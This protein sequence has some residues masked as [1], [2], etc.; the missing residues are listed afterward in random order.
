MQDDSADP[1]LTDLTAALETARREGSR[2]ERAIA[3]H[4]LRHLGALP[5]ETAASV[6]QKI[7]VSEST[8][9]RFCR[10]LGYAHFKALKAALQTDPG[11]GPWLIGDRLRAFHGRALQGDAALAQGMERE[12]A[13]I[14]ANYE[15]AA[16]P[17]FAR[18]AARLAR[19][20]AVWIAGF[21]TERGHAADLAHT[22]QYLRPGVQLADLSGGHFSEVLLSSPAETCLVLF[23]GRRYSRLTRA[24]AQAARQKGIAVTLITDPWCDWGQ[25]LADECLAVQTDLGQ[26]WDS[27]AAM[28]SL[29][30]LL[31][32]RV[33]REL[34][35][36][37]VEARLAQVAGL[38]NDFIGQIGGA[39]GAGR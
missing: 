19:C 36:E 13:A 3:G 17:G 24:L 4:F 25:D 37:T 35:A 7:G 12:L 16:T 30:A 5:F 21:Q 33:F 10:E 32:N 22:L 2:S 28:A 8:V 15:L 11:D 26:F 9:G 34:G 6:A 31:V 29:N 14:A 1:A 18:A 27:T 23:D 39:R 38:Y 20:P